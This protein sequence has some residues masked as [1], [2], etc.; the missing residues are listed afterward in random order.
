ML[1]II[2]TLSITNP[3]DTLRNNDV[4][5]TSRRRHFDV[6]ASKWRRY[7]VIT[8]LLL[9]HVV[10]GKIQ[11]FFFV[12]PMSLLNWG[13]RQPYF[14]NGAITYNLSLIHCGLSYFW[15]VKCV[16]DEM[17]VWPWWHSMTLLNPSEFKAAN[18][19]LHWSMLTTMIII[20]MMMIMMIA[21]INIQGSWGILHK[22]VFS[23]LSNLKLHKI[24]PVNQ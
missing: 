12:R 16:P 15:I 7:Y 13:H 24:S 2:G 10:S 21:N 11:C 1:D 14:D 5:I 9:R 4:V 3:A 8:T 19:C 23:N 18:S 6:I 22:N 17:I 20:I